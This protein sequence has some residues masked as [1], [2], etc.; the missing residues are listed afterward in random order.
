MRDPKERLRDILE[1]IARIER[2][3]SRGREAF[4]QDELIQCWFTSTSEWTSTRSGQPWRAICPPSSAPS[5]SCSKHWRVRNEAAPGPVATGKPS[6]RRWTR[7]RPRAPQGAGPW[8]LTTC[9]ANGARRSSASPPSMAPATS[10]CSGLPLA[11]RRATRAMSTSS[12]SSS[13]E[14]RFSIRR[15]CSSSW[16]APQAE[17]R[18]GHRGQPLLAPAAPHPQ[19]GDLDVHYAPEVHGPARGAG[20]RCR[21]LVEWCRGAAEPLCA[22]HDGREV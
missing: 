10:A 17:G 22:A 13:Q 7:L 6:P 4:E 20:D 21:S 1:A 2:Y 15:A 5:R 3:A 8:L 9:S 11:A 14:G 16:R 12:S 18:R 19:G